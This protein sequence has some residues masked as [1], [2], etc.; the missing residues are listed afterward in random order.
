MLQDSLSVSSSRVK[1]PK[2]KAGQQMDLLLLHGLWCGWLNGSLGGKG[3][4][5]VA[6]AKSF[7]QGMEGRINGKSSWKDTPE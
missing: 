2:K 4:N 6:G 3:A 7:Y 5:K 1:Q